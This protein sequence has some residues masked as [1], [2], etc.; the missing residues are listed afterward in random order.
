MGVIKTALEIALEKTEKVKG[1]KSSIDQFDAKQRGKKLANTFLAGEADIA[2]EIKNTSAGQQYSLKQG[3][4]EVLISQ[5]T[6]PS[7]EEDKKRI[8]LAGRGLQ[9]I[10]GGSQIQ[11]IYR[12]MTALFA[13]YLQEAAHYEQAIRQQYSPKLRQKEEEI[14]RRLGR[15]VR[16][17]PLQDPEFAAFYNQ[18]MN[19]LKGKYEPVVEEVKAEIRALFSE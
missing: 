14:A 12:Q 15:E 1:D 9:T 18:H 5:I 13:Q 7:G 4:F 19:A 11:T 6:L 2:S 16:L 10:I 8:E 3:V 17:D